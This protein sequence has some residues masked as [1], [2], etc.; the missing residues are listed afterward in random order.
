MRS[1]VLQHPNGTSVVLLGTQHVSATHGCL[2]REQ[3]EF[4]TPTAV[5]LELDQV[6]MGFY[7]SVQGHLLF[8]CARKFRT[9]SSADQALLAAH[10]KQH[11]L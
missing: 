11:T 8:T 4:G 1:E 9:M 3:I 7:S 2:A 10:R 5:V 6:C